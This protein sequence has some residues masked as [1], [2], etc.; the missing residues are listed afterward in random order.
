MQIIIG[1]ALCLVFFLCLGGSFYAGYKFRD[2]RPKS[3]LKE[4]SD[5]ERYEMQK[6]QEGFL[7]VMNYNVDKA[8]GFKGGK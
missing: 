1:F 4:L 3:K 2:K 8:M 6:K 7:N 5:Q